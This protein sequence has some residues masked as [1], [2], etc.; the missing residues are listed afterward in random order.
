ME[1]GRLWRGL[2]YAGYLVG[3]VLFASALIGGPVGGPAAAVAT[4]LGDSTL[5]LVAS[6]VLIV[7]GRSL[8]QYGVDPNAGT[9]STDEDGETVIVCEECGAENDPEYQFCGE[10][11]AELSE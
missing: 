6:V 7:G 11:S 2:G 1:H 4:V 10:C 5:V 9:R 3:L 8:S